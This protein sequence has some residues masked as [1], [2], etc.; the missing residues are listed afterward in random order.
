MWIR[1]ARI[2]R[3]VQALDRRHALLFCAASAGVIA[4][5]LLARE[6]L[7]CDALRDLSGQDCPT[8][9]CSR[10]ARGTGAARRDAETRRWYVEFHCARCGERFWRTSEALHALVERLERD[11][12]CVVTDPSR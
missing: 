1:S 5:K 8:P 6:A 3:R 4:S 11:G 2:G 9:R 12:A 7:V 10:D